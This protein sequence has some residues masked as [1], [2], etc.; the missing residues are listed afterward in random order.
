MTS[1]TNQS[2]LVA[3]SGGVDSAVA[4][5]LLIERG[6]DVTGVTLRLLDAARGTHYKASACTDATI[7]AARS[8]AERLGIPHHVLDVS[9]LFERS[10]IDYLLSE[11]RKG[12][13]PN[14]CIRCNAVVKLRV[15]VENRESLGARYVATGH[16]VRKIEDQ[17][18]GNRVGLGRAADPVKD[19]SYMLSALTQPLLAHA[20]FPL[21]DMCKDEVRDYAKRLDVPGVER[22]ESQDV[23]FAPDGDYRRL[24]AMFEVAPQPGPIL[25]T[26][27]ET[28]G[29]HNGL[30]L[31]TIGQRKGL[32]LAA[33]RPYYVVDID[34]ARNALIVGHAE[35]TY[36]RG[37][38]AKDVNWCS[39]PPRDEPFDCLVRIRYLHTPV[40]ARVS[41]GRTGL[42][43]RFAEPQRAVTPGQWAVLYDARGRLLA[44]GEIDAA[45]A[46]AV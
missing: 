27:G 23:C 14:P 18:A 9:H 35:S 31:Y 45:Y 44:G 20:L 42:D 7:I 21:G 16:Y 15:L 24:F 38:V 6:Y 28:L 22:P 43:I 5:A 8:T 3:L 29:S 4:A 26:A 37:L 1:V 36:S 10:V 39:V 34:P 13:T 41:P 2:V 46:T 25:S 11:Y 19:Q 40:P 33:D 17:G 30:H 32:G 12:K